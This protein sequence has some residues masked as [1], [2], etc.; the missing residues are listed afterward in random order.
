MSTF[1]WWSLLLILSFLLFFFTAKLLYNFV[2]DTFCE[3]DNNT[4]SNQQKKQIS[5]EDLTRYTGDFR[6]I[7]KNVEFLDESDQTDRHSLKKTPEEPTFSARE[8][9]KPPIQDEN[10]REDF[11]L[12]DKDEILKEID[13]EN[14]D[15]L[16]DEEKKNLNIINGIQG[17]AK[18]YAQQI[19]YFLGS[20]KHLQY[21]EM[22]E[23]FI[24][25]LITL[26]E[27]DTKS[28]DVVKRRKTEVTNYIQNCQEQLKTKA[29]QYVY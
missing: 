12:V 26:G 27:L 13:R 5:Y 24:R 4:P 2:C 7:V 17:E 29:D 21:F 1:V 25:C 14:Q 19:P 18:I 28:S 22:N 15:Q 10:H 3:E 9:Q 16:S 6:Q 8:P 20:N 11:V 23:K